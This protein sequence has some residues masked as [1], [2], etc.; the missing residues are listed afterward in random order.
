MMIPFPN[1]VACELH[2]SFSRKKLTMLDNIAIVGGGLTGLALAKTLEQRGFDY[3]LF[4][5]R[6]R[7]GGRILSRQCLVPDISVD[8]GPTWYWSRTQAAMVKLVEEVGLTTFPQCDDGTVWVLT[9][10]NERPQKL[11]D[12]M[13]HAGARRLPEGWPG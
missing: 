8:L 6:D 3:S 4:E 5:A 12:E 10:P 13:L 7:L 9:D 2:R 11:E 1:P